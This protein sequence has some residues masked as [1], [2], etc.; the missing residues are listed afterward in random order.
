MIVD[1]IKFIEKYKNLD[2]RVELALEFLEQ[3]NFK[4]I[5][6]GIYKISGDD[7]FYIVSEYKTR[8]AQEGKLEGHEKYIDIQSV[9]HGEEMIGYSPLTNQVV[10]SEYNK[11]KDYALYEGSASLIKMIPGMFAIFYPNDL[12]MP[13]ICNM[14]KTVKKLVIKVKLL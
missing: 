12:H 8:P 13:G 4:D 5:A 11:E 1:Q 14:K 2:G 6:P 7:L 9:I 10:T 3:T